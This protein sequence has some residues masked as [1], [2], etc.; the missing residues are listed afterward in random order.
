MIVAELYASGAIAGV[1]NTIVANP[2][3]NVGWSGASHSAMQNTVD[4]C[5]AKAAPHGLGSN[6]PH[7]GA[8]PSRVSGI[9][10]PKTIGSRDVPFG[11]LFRHK[12]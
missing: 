6:K 1:A 4:A 8:L 2:V 9:A 10:V 3:K 7:V 5:T 12:C 11:H